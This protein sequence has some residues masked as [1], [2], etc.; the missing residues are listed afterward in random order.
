L[1]LNYNQHYKLNFLAKL[2]PEN[3]ILLQRTELYKSALMAQG[4]TPGA[5]ASISNMLI[6]KS[7]GIQSQLLTIRA[8]FLLGA[9]LMA[10]AFVVL[11][12][13]AVINKVKA[14]RSKA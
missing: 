10:I 3:E 2:I 11:I 6:A 5:A 12:V 9:V 1:Q 4:A 14:A 13:F 8:I 7:T